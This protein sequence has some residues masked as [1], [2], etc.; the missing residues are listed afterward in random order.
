[1]LRYLLRRIA[2]Y[3]LLL[4]MATTMAYFIAGTQL[5]PR[6]KLI[7]ERLSSGKNQ[8]RAEIE[9]S[10]DRLLNGYN[11]NPNTSI[12]ERYWN[13]LK[14]VVFHFDWG[15]A[16]D[17]S[18]VNTEIANRV[19]LS[20]QLVFLGFFIGIFVGVALGAYSAVKQYSAFDRVT[21]FIVMLLISTPSIVLAI[22]LQMLTIKMNQTLGTDLSFSGPYSVP[23]PDGTFAALMDRLEHLLL[24]TI[25]MS[26]G[27]IAVYS[28]YQRNLMLDT[29]GADYV[30]TAR[31]KG[32]R[33]AKAV[34]L[35]ALRTSLIP[36]A[37]YFA[38]GIAGL[39]TGAAIT[40]QIFGW[41]GMGIY[42]INTIQLMDINGT[43]SVVAFGGACTLTGALLSDMLIAAIDPRVRVG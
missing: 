32:L 8:T 12:F 24:P 15:Y 3:V 30:R 28:R 26:L 6:A 21:T 31:A 13:W 17:G 42:A 22:L 1:M 27:G 34:R 18:H 20:L 19:P 38:F 4:F 9:A 16:P 29:L 35:H 2:N 36:V 23:Q 14:N 11:I 43:V 40:E 25:A 5:N 10:V 39:I 37:T 33:F 7:Q 41:Q